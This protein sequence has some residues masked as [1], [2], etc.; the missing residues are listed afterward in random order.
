MLSLRHGVGFPIACHDEADRMASWIARQAL[1]SAAQ[2]IRGCAQGM[3]Q[4]R[5]ARR[6]VNMV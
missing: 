2:G 6:V 3:S 4:C 5:K 1:F